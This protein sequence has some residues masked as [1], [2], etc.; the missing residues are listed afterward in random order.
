MAE[1][2]EAGFFS[3]LEEQFLKE[4]EAG[5]DL[6]QQ[7]LIEREM[8]AHKLWVSFQD[9]ATAVAHLFRGKVQYHGVCKLGSP[10]W[11]PLS[12]SPLYPFYLIWDLVK[13]FAISR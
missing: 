13:P 10:L 8:A 6:D 11:V 12:G 9:S 3:P 4:S 5:E 2:R 1:G 7:L